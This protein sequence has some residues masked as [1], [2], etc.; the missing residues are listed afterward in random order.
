[1]D[2]EKKSKNPPGIRAEAHGVEG[3]RPLGPALTDRLVLSPLRSYAFMSKAS[4]KHFQAKCSGQAALG[5]T[6][7]M[8]CLRLLT[9]Y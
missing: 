4:L 9:H 8:S 1:M 2:P 5:I 7:P 3:S 6:S